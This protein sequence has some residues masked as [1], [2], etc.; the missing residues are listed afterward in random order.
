MDDEE[1][2]KARVRANFQEARE[3][4]EALY[5]QVSLRPEDFGAVAEE[6]PT[7]TKPAEHSPPEP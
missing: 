4:I 6:H 3:A 5:K 1:E 7:S 2:R